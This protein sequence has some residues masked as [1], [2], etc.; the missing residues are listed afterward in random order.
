MAIR[1]P[2]YIEAEYTQDVEKGDTWGITTDDG[3]LDEQLHNVLATKRKPRALSV[4]KDE[5]RN[6]SVSVAG[7][8]IPQM[9]NHLCF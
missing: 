8:D 6:V 2:E 9:E 5:R 1:D 4:Y 7:G 3:M